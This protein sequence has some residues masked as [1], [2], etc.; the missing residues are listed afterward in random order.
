MLFS[1]FM[2]NLDDVTKCA[3]SKFAGGTR[4]GGVADLP[5]GGALIQ[6]HTEE[7]ED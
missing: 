3:L 6:R 1:I 2:G 7:P 4:L 5:S